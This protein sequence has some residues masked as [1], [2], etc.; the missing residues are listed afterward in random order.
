MTVS[1]RSFFAFLGG[2]ALAPIALRLP[3]YEPT[4]GVGMTFINTSQSNVATLSLRD[5][6]AAIKVMRENKI[7]DPIF[8]L[9]PAEN[10]ILGKEFRKRGY[11]TLESQMIGEVRAR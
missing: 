10:S 2:A 3:A 9:H 1:R 8:I 11:F 7:R 6:E 4:V 5:I